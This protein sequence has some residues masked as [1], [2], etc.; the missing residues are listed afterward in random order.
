MICFDQCPH[1]IV[2][3]QTGSISEDRS[4]EP[5]ISGGFYPRTIENNVVKESQAIKLKE[6]KLCAAIFQNQTPTVMYTPGFSGSQII[7]GNKTG[8]T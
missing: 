3:C 2:G 4:V 5:H 6:F 8:K 7:I 1:G